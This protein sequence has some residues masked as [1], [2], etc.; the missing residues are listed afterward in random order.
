MSLAAPPAIDMYQGTD[1]LA[2]VAALAGHRTVRPAGRTP[3]ITV[4]VLN[5]DRAD[6]IVPMLDAV[7]AIAADLR[8]RGLDLQFLVGDTGSR[9][10]RVLAAYEGASAQ[11]S[12]V[13]GLRYQFS[14]SNND[15][16]DA[17]V[18]HD[19]VVFL[20]N[21][22]HLRSGGPLIAMWEQLADPAVGAAGL[23]LDLPDGRLQHAG[24][25]FVTS[26]PHRLLPHH[27]RAGRNYRH[28]LGKSW[29]VPA[30]TGAALM[31]RTCDWAALGGLDEA[32]ERECQDVDLCLRLHRLGLVTRVVDVGPLIHEE[33]GTRPKGEEHWADR[34]LYLR[35]WSAY[36]QA[37][38]L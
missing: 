27:A 34:R 4:A 17:R 23:V 7:P 29:Q 13:R 3:G 32:Y 30:V 10:P 22:V 5:L 1:N 11:V 26:G 38:G 36:I 28:E 24:I 15:V 8:A 14:R 21:D 33:N 16:C 25:D 18:A 2:R 20:N 35:R 31:L 19:H 9:D 6:L 12:V 37:A